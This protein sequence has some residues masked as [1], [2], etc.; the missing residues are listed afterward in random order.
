MFPGYIRRPFISESAG[1]VETW[2]RIVLEGIERQL[3]ERRRRFVRWKTARRDACTP[4]RPV[5]S[6]LDDISLDSCSRERIIDKCIG[7][8]VSTGCQRETDTR[9][10][11]PIDAARSCFID[12]R[13]PYLSA[14]LISG[15]PFLRPGISL[16]SKASSRER[17]TGR[18]RDAKESD[19]AATF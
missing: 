9:R 6:I 19:A 12:A 13:N 2:R 18:R 8:V 17:G 14:G 10:Q 11:R 3:L 15:N 16:V 7:A 4:A 1:N 5:R